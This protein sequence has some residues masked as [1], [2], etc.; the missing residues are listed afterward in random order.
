MITRFDIDERVREWSLREDVVEKDYVLGWLLWGIGV[1]EVLGLNWVFKGGTCL[2]KCYIETYRFSEDLD[3]TIL[4]G[5]PVREEDVR[6]PLMRVLERVHEQ[7]GILFNDRMPLLKTHESG[8]Y[9]QGRIYYRGPRN[10]PQVASVILDLSASEKVARPPVLREIAHAFPDTLPVPGKVRCY[11]FEEVFAEKI[12]AMGERC[13]PRDLYDIVNLFRRHDLR[14][15]AG[16]VREV[17]H[18]KCAGKGVPVPTMALL[19]ESPH[20]VALASEWGNMLG[21]QLPSLPPFEA[22]WEELPSLFSWLEGTLDDVELKTAT[23]QSPGDAIDDEWTPPA[24]AFVWGQGVPIETIRFAASNHLC[25]DLG[26]Q[27]SVRTIEPYALRRSKA[28]RVL[29]VAIKTATRETRTYRLDRIESVRV[30]NRPFKPAYKVEIGSSGP[31]IIPALS[32]RGTERPFAVR[33]MSRP[34][35]PIAR[36]YGPTY[37]IK[38]SACGREFKRSTMNY[39]LKPHKGRGGWNCHSVSGYLVRTE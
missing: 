31:V 34:G 38:C 27:G 30:T 36:R 24:T 15:A 18:E 17:L 11:S 21:H 3:F 37:V 2:K 6:P 12:R 13:R 28:N 29:L 33:S 39:L 32:H 23:A 20:R 19:E 5:G 35:R 16:L 22:F 1:D 7:S 8:L 26:Y 9:T 25:L 10:T 4:P 14:S